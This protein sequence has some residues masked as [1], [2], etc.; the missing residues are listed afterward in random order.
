[1][2][3][4][5]AFTL[6][7]KINPTLPHMNVQLTFVTKWLFWNLIKISQIQ[8]KAKLSALKIYFIIFLNFQIW[9]QMHHQSSQKICFKYSRSIR[10]FPINHATKQNPPT[11]TQNDLNKNPQDVELGKKP[12]FGWISLR[13][14]R[15]H[16]QLCR[17]TSSR[18]RL[19]VPCDLRDNAVISLA[20]FSIKLCQ[21][22]S[23]FVNYDIS[24]LA[25]TISQP[26]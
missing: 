3:Q 4:S 25:G 20:N 24:Q 11:I 15:L 17:S 14:L 22:S 9:G 6:L 21:R 2:R 5:R 16:T 26:L 23:N 18:S 10:I 7:N 13:F 19:R 12:T 1:M 8:L